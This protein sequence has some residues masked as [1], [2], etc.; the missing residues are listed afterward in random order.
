M[1]T[2]YLPMRPRIQPHVTREFGLPGRCLTWRKVSAWRQD[3]SRRSFLPVRQFPCM[4]NLMLTDRPN[5]GGGSSD[6]RCGLPSKGYELDLIRFI[7]RIY[8]D[9][10]SNVA[11]LK[12]W[13]EIG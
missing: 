4:R 12:P 10:N 7:P 5:L 1:G 3:Y 6:N 8:M 2:R 11:R 9:D 13:S